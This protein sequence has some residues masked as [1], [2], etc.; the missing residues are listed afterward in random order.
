M[1]KDQATMA[2]IGVAGNNL[3]SSTVATPWR[4]SD[5]I[6][7]LVIATCV[8]MKNLGFIIV[9]PKLKEMTRACPKPNDLGLSIE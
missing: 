8:P 1:Q 7:R 2:A 6:L 9:N 5:L 4:H 3:P